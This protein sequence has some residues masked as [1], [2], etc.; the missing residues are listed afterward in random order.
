MPTKVIVFAAL[1]QIK[2][3][4][5]VFLIILHII[6][7]LRWSESGTESITVISFLCDSFVASK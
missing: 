4:S 7:S 3:H 1:C 5:V 2:K 6:L